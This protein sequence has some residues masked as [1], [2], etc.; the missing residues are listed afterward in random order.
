MKRRQLLALPAALLLAR[1]ARAQAEAWPARPV[2][3]LVPYGAGN[4]ADQVAR[5]LAEHLSQRWNQRVVVDNL[6]GAGGALGT[7]QL[8]RAPADGYTLGVVAV[9]AL[10]ITPHL[11]KPAPYDPPRDLTPVAGVTASRTFLVVRTDLPARNLAEFV[12][13]ARARPADKLL[14]Y[15][16]AGNG[17]IPH[18]NT[19]LLARALDFRA[20]HVP[21]RA[22]SAGVVD[23]IA[24]R[25]DFTMDSS[26]VTL[27]HVKNGTLRALFY[28]GPRRFP[29]QPAVPT[30][31]EA[32]RGLTL[33][34]AWQ[35]VFAPRGLD[36]KLVGRI[37]S[38]VAE[39]VALP[40]F[41]ERLPAGSE[42][43]AASAREVAELM[44]ADHERFGRV[45][46]EIGLKAD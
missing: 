28:N 12:A 3:M 16:S 23:L 11:T 40:A 15:Y 4:Q 37:S 8:V 38:D 43:F 14:V 26:N 36:P 17:T 41:A 2:R 5:V 42:P 10:A 34:N 46:A 9:A 7:A 1:G 24:G 30:L 29:D 19:E 39:I 33:P 31:G 21:Y 25:I 13:L 35:G 45:V 6:P 18:L 27:P 20:L 44:R 32:A 22:S